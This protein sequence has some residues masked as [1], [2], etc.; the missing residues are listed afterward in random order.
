MSIIEAAAAFI[1]GKST[2]QP[3]VGLILGSGL[4]EFADAIAEKG[5][6]IA[7]DRIPHFP[8]P[9]VPGHV[10]RLVIG[11]L[12]GADVLMMQGRC[13]YYEGHE[14]SAVVFPVRVMARL[15]IRMLIVTN[16]AGGLSKRFKVGDLMIISDHINLMGM[17]PL[18]GAN[19]DELGP[20]FPD[21]TAAYDIDLQK[22]ALRVAR[23]LGFRLR[24]GVYAAM[25]GPSYETP[26]EI[27]ML[28]KLGAD[29]VG[30]STVPEVIAAR[31]A[32]MRVLGISCIT[33]YA[34]GVSRKPLSHEEVL[35]TTHR[36][37]GRFSRLLTAIVAQ[38]G[39]GGKQKAHR[40]TKL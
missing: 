15:G 27:H 9:S 12:R 36:V 29:A 13:H 39:D 32:G 23:S 14:L 5:L 16:S 18:R 4:G 6:T 10:G 21:M 28:R 38:L 17:N 33:N 8:V 20:R 25:S 24:R 37:R 22:L 30:M 2:L 40:S 34:A 26:A 35:E 19:L 7:Y 1:R 11:K 3:Q 31:H